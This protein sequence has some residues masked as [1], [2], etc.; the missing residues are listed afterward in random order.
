M[1]WIADVIRASEAQSLERSFAPLGTRMREA[2]FGAKL[3]FGAA[4]FVKCE[5]CFLAD[6]D[7]RLLCRRGSVRESSAGGTLT[8]AGRSF[9][10]FTSFFQ[11]LCS[12]P[13]AQIWRRWQRNG[14]DFRNKASTVA[15]AAK[16][17]SSQKTSIV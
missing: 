12:L 7:G 17:A 10:F 3:S 11:R 5:E 6:G 8:C 14:C 4:L 16:V 9:F 1:R 2:L 13:D 15:L